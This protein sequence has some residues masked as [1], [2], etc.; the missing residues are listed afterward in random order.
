MGNSPEKKTE[1]M[2]FF[3]E[4]AMKAKITKAASTARITVSEFLRRTIQARLDQS[5]LVDKLVDE[6]QDIEPIASTESYMLAVTGLI[7]QSVKKHFGKT[8]RKGIDYGLTMGA[9]RDP[10]KEEVAVKQ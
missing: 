10:T 5:T 9:G 2:N 3:V 7:E 4:P 6:L 1:S 8:F